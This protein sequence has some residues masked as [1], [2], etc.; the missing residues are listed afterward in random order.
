MN[1][2]NSSNLPQIRAVLFDC[3]G[4]FFPDSVDEYIKNHQL[5]PNVIENLTAIDDRSSWGLLSEDEYL[6][7]LSTLLGIPIEACS[8]ELLSKEHVNETILRLSQQIRKNYK[9]GL[10]SNV[11][12]GTMP[13]YFSDADLA[14]YF[15]AAILSCDYKIAKP[16]ARIF[17]IAC[18]KLGVAPSA[19]VFIDDSPEYCAGAD[20]A[21]LHTIHYTSYNNLVSQLQPII[22]I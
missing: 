16:D 9:L 1:T 20:R 10:L 15:D 19:T 18:N 4:L 21:G 5:A 6:Q 7:E 3:F 22:Q 12:L 14:S 13:R 8:K 17:E 11:G 2:N